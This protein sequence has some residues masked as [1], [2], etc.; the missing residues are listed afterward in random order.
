MREGRE[1]EET[2]GSEARRGKKMRMIRRRTQEGIENHG[3]GRYNG[4][5]EGYGQG[6]CRDKVVGHGQGQCWGKVEG[7]GQG[8]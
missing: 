3:Q 1:R 5:F 8:Q 6:Q 7:H 2:P 4:K